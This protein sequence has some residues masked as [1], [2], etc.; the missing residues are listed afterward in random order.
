MMPQIA[1]ENLPDYMTYLKKMGVGVE[2]T[3]M[4]VG[5]MK[6]AQGE[7]VVNKKSSDEN[8]AMLKE[9]GGK[10]I[11]G[12]S[13]VGDNV[14]VKTSAGMINATAGEM[15]FDPK[16]A[17][18]NRPLLEAVNQQNAPAKAPTPEP[19][20]PHFA[21][22]TPDLGGMAKGMTPEM[23]AMILAGLS[24]EDR[25][26]ITG[27]A[28]PAAAVPAGP[29]VTA[30]PRH[31][32]TGNEPWS[33]EST[34]KQVLSAI[35][36]Q[37]AAAVSPASV[38]PVPSSAPPIGPPS[39]P[40]QFGGMTQLATSGPGPAAAPQFGPPTSE[41]ENSPQAASYSLFKQ[42]REDSETEMRGAP[43]R[44]MAER[45]AAAAAVEEEEKRKA[46][47]GP[48]N[49]P[50]AGYEGGPAGPRTSD[51][52][53]SLPE[54]T[55]A[56][57][58]KTLADTF[59]E[60]LK[61]L[62]PGF[63]KGAITAVG[64]EVGGPVGGLIAHAMSDKLVQ[65]L[66]KMGTG[67]KGGVAEATGGFLDKI[68][69]YIGIGGKPA[70]GGAP[71][72][73]P[74]GG[75][76]DMLSNLLGGGGGGAG[77]PAGGVPAA[78]GAGG[79][80]G[81]GAGVAGGAGAAEAAGPAAAGG[82][83]SAAS[84]GA[85]AGPIGIAITAALALKAVSDKVFEGM[86]KV[87]DVVPGVAEGFGKLIGM[88]ESVS[89]AMGAMTAVM[90]TPAHM[91]AEGLHSIVSPIE[92]LKDPLK[93]VRI[94]FDSAATAGLAVGKAMWDMRDPMQMLNQAVAP[95]VSQI[96]KFNPGI[97]SIMNL[98]FE[99]ASAAAGR[100]FEPVAIAATGFADELNRLYT[101][102][103]GPIREFVGEL[104]G[105]ARSAARELAV[106]F[107]G[108]VQEGI[109]VARQMLADLAPLAPVARQMLRGFMELAGGAIKFGGELFGGAM[110][111]L[112]PIIDGARPFVMM[113]WEAGRSAMTL[114]RA[115]WTIGEAL[116]GAGAAVG[117]FV[118]WIWSFTPIGAAVSFAGRNLVTVFQYLGAGASALA[119]VM[120][121][122]ANRI[123]HPIDYA[124]TV[125]RRGVLGVAAD[126]RAAIAR[127]FRASLARMQAPSSA[128]ASPLSS[129]AMTFAAQQARHVG[130]EDVGLEARRSAFSMGSDPATQ[131]ATNT[132]ATAQATQA[133]L[134]VL[135]QMMIQ[136]GQIAPDPMM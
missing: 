116:L 121:R 89:A 22:G 120:S 5:A 65:S 49:Q 6:Y 115:A 12:D 64:Y 52:V 79:A 69:S 92:F 10:T 19:E 31:R 16:T 114:G 42:Q 28:A 93:V 128:A 11:K 21:S 97:V 63:L 84:L 35:A 15:I 39:A 101:S 62:L 80:G 50:K 78:A 66:D 38:G 100:M 86:H 8:S 33:L 14:P 96:S 37:P 55:A 34:Q 9:L 25:A 102:S 13:A 104:S 75:L 48:V 72:G 29:A 57:A 17:A 110:R 129:G 76:T 124:A 46:F 83:S 67:G 109:P 135:R 119:G 61:G 74:G 130:I 73:A 51:F 118:G 85:A 45:R 99:N 98:S 87:I 44:S 58:A 94:G 54:A 117:R 134:V 27:A 125:A 103:A 91:V 82:A 133:M 26:K 111:F 53:R 3:S 107:M 112:T 30:G 24:P 43:D 88:P 36:S 106:G 56:P 23:Q 60:S 108:L 132:A 126:E 131:T 136:N 7:F 1:R 47:I 32:P 90:M 68:G 81:A 2:R 122:A 95:F 4:P 105:V 18:Q 40:T 59:V 127:D 71:G 20:A 41:Y 113:L 123:A 77:V 70:A